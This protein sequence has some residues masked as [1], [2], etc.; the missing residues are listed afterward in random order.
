MQ[1]FL[2]VNTSVTVTK[3]GLE[4]SWHMSENITQGLTKAECHLQVDIRQHSAYSLTLTFQ[5]F[6][7]L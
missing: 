5:L 1:R 7:F 2:S 4:N 6:F 3:P